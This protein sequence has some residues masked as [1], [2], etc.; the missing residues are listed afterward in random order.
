LEEAYSKCAQFYAEDKRQQSDEFGKK[1][2]SCFY[3]IGKTEVA[4]S[5]IDA[6]RKK[7]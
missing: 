7:L 3:F 5:Q 2:M 6:S 4:V 1:V